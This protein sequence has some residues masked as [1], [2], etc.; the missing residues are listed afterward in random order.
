MTKNSK[1]SKGKT[2]KKPHKIDDLDFWQATE[3]MI[4]EIMKS[5]DEAAR[6]KAISLYLKWQDLRAKSD[7]KG[8][9]GDI[10]DPAIKAFLGDAVDRLLRGDYVDVDDLDDED[11][12]DE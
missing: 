7:A 12:D 1:E 9:V 5:S 6:L 4:R 10:I 11:L 8:Q 3:E 2:T